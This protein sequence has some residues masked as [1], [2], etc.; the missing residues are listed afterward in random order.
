MLVLCQALLIPPFT[1]GN[2]TD[3]TVY[4]AFHLD[5]I[6]DYIAPEEAEHHVKIL[7]QMLRIPDASGA[8]S[9]LD[10]YIDDNNV[11]QMLARFAYLAQRF[12]EDKKCPRLSEY[13]TKN[14]KY[15]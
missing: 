12:D 9:I 8:R 14:G 1:Y 3:T 6:V 7:R 10:I 5:E 15:A 11:S 13:L 2:N 4:V